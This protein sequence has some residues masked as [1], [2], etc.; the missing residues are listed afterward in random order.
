MHGCTQPSLNHTQAYTHI[1]GICTHN[2]ACL[3]TLLTHTHHS[4]GLEPSCDD[5]R[6]SHPTLKTTRLDFP[7]RK[8]LN[9]SL[10]SSSVIVNLS[11]HCIHIQTAGVFKLQSRVQL[12]SFR[13]DFGGCMQLGEHDLLVFPLKKR[14]YRCSNLQ[15]FIQSIN[16]VRYDAKMLHIHWS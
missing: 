10:Y 12:G 16:Q 9:N 2:F 13:G 7:G 3:A 5:N 14:I 1:Y 4:G 11:H 15:P 6:G 8:R